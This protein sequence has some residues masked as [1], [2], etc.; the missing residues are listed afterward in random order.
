MDR[1]S[2]NCIVCA[3]EFASDDLQSLALSKINVTNFKIC[4]S[5]FDNSNPSEDY[6]EARIIVASYNHMQ[7]TLSLFDEVKDILNSQDD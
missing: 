1:V 6:R 4:Q 5:C 3:E 7:E 2:C